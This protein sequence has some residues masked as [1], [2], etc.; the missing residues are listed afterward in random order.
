[1]TSGAGKRGHEIQR[2]VQTH[3]SRHISSISITSRHIRRRHLLFTVG[4][5]GWLPVYLHLRGRRRGHRWRRRLLWLH[6]NGHDRVRSFGPGGDGG[7]GS[8]VL[9]GR[10]RG[11]EDEDGAAGVTVDVGGDDLVGVEGVGRQ[12]DVGEMHHVYKNK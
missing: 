6:T 4:T 12:R 5:A 11:A 7:G 1:M 3:E 9:G 2:R 10:G 8:G